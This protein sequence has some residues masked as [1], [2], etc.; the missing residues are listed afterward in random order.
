MPETAESHARESQVRYGGRRDHPIRRGLRGWGVARR[1]AAFGPGWVFIGVAA[2]AAAVL[3]ATFGRAGGRWWYEAVVSQL[4]FRRR[5]RLAAAHVIAA[6][7][8][9]HSGPPQ[10]PWLRTLAPTLVMR[11][12]KV[13]TITVGVGSDQGG[14]YAAVEVGSFWDDESLAG[15]QPGSA[16]DSPWAPGAVLPRPAGPVP[17]QELAAL[18]EA[19][20]DRAA[21]SCVQVVIARAVNRPSTSGLGRRTRVAGGRPGHR[22]VRWSRGGGADGGR[23]GATGRTHPG[24]PRLAGSGRRRRRPTRDARRSHRPR[25]SAAGTGVWRSGRLA[26]THYDVTGGLRPRHARWG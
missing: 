18:T 15:A 7:V 22:A 12:V 3:V 17:Y 26:R 13:G 20:V 25:R 2:L 9:G 24:R 21:V 16:A 8:G 10:L 6:A 5:R 14:W 1:A 23:S 4:R 11:R 19:D